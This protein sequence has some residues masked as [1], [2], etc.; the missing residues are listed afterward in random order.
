MWDEMERGEG[1]E[2]GIKMDLLHHPIYT[3]HLAPR[4]SAQPIYCGV[5]R[6]QG[7]RPTH[8]I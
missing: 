3:H 8:L 1:W 6:I 5:R 7:F 2:M 4:N